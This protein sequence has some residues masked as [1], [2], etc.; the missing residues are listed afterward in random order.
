VVLTLLDDI[1]GVLGYRPAES[2]AIRIRRPRRAF[3]VLRLDLPSRVP[4]DLTT[5]A[6]VVT[7]MLARMS[8]VGAIDIVAFGSDHSHA[9]W[10]AGP[11]DPPNDAERERLTAVVSALASA[12]DAAGFT[13]AS[14]WCVSDSHCARSDSSR[15]RS[16][17]SWMPLR[18]STSAAPAPATAEPASAPTAFTPS[19]GHDGSASRPV[20][21]V[22]PVAGETFTGRT[23]TSQDAPSGDPHHGRFVPIARAEERRRVHALAALEAL[24]DEE[25]DVVDLLAAWGSALVLDPGELS[26]ARAVWLGR[27]L[28]RRLVRDC[29]LMQCAWGYESG[30]LA[31]R[32]SLAGPTRPG[33][34]FD[35]FIGVGER[36]PDP[37]RL[38][39]AVAL[40]RRITE[41]SPDTFCAAPFTMLAWLEWCRGRGSVA[42]AY[43]GLA[44]EADPSNQLALLF[45]QL[46]DS[47]C[48]P[49]WIS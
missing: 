14:G 32:E 17:R 5:F 35:T 47:A 31:L 13:V 8:G 38:R 12:A 26:D 33:G 40:L 7:G 11:A 41:C 10:P 24:G 9:A 39:S 15:L 29:V 49:Q 18:P 48:L 22:D 6:S 37:R 36:A 30:L 23:T 16:R 19:S 25:V 27:S 34:A 28:Q 46:V 43:L 4:P 45:S 1:D 21:P 3:A 2:V 44:L 20:H 42:S